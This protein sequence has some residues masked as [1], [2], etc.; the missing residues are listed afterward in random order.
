MNNQ[1]FRLLFLL[2]FC[3]NLTSCA[4]SDRVVYED[5]E[6]LIPK[7]VF[8]KIENTNAR[9]KVVT[10]H[11]GEPDHV[12]KISEELAVY[13]YRLQRTHIRNG[14]LLFLFRSGGRVDDLVYYHVAIKNDVVK[15]AWSDDSASVSIKDRRLRSLATLSVDVSN[16]KSSR[17]LFNWKLPF[18]KKKPAAENK[19]NLDSSAYVN[20]TNKNEAISAA[21][22]AAVEGGSTSRDI[23][24]GETA[25]EARQKEPASGE[26]TTPSPPVII[27]QKELDFG[28]KN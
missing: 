28:D 25:D 21:R 5:S 12:D 8:D 23:A 20:A 17:F 13:T 22:K 1:V 2:V 4:L 16:Q 24:V 26:I 11:F 7:T 27:N 3:V 10:A 6:G 14:H 18:M 15:K 9:K 19:K